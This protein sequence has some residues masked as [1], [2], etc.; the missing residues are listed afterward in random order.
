MPSTL[1]KKRLRRKHR[2]HRAHARTASHVRRSGGPRVYHDEHVVLPP[3]AQPP[4]PDPNPNPGGKVPPPPDANHRNAER[5]LWRA[6]FGPRPGGV[7]HVISVGIPAAVRELTHP[8]GAARLNGPEPADE[9]GNALAPDDAWGHDHLWWLD[10]M[11][12]SDQ[13]LVERMTLIWHDWFATSNDKVGSQ[14]L[15]LQ[16]NATMRANALGSFSDLLKA[17]TQDPAMLVWLDGI[18]NQD[19]DVNENYGRE[20]MELFT[21]G[22]DR[23]AYTEQ[24][25]REL[26]RAFTG[27]D[28]TWVDGSGFQNFR[29]DPSRHDSGS[30]TVFGK[31]GNFDWQDAIRLCLENPFHA[32]FF[33]TKLWS[34]FIPT[35][36]DQATQA[37]LQ[38]LYVSSGYGIAPVVEAILKHPDLYSDRALVKPPI[39]FNA[40][41]LRML[42]RGID[43]SAWAWLG[44]QSGQH[45]FI[46]PNVSGWDDSSWLDTST[47]RG[48]SYMVTYALEPKH[49]DP[50]GDQKYDANEDAATAVARALEFTGNPTL[51]TE[52]R[53]ALVSFAGSCLPATMR[54]WEQSPFRAMRQNALRHLI[55]TSSD[56]QAS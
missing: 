47:W 28:A 23:G 21:L 41:L 17:L 1:P 43:T 26:A 51:S 55:L 15:M 29:F 4:K 44:D 40:G 37:A 7:E 38:K 54:P 34:Y 10:R 2:R 22:A 45:L 53:K 33:V 30:K 50:W 49:V 36:P 32:S 14:H 3:P 31:T 6:G 39:V 24:D 8:S 11:V 25:V 35:P 5:L 27:F 16:Q 18:A 20:V 48:R 52:G 13:Q 56:W 42:G 19:G 12:R 46:P 9:D